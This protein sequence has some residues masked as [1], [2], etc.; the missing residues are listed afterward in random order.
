MRD[1]VREKFHERSIMEEIRST[2]E[3][4]GVQSLFPL[5]PGLSNS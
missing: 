5:T 4:I 3:T 1:T 2:F